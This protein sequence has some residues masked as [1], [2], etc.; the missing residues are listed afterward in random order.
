MN[1]T[2]YLLVGKVVVIKHP[3]LNTKQFNEFF[4]HYSFFSVKEASKTVWYSGIVVVGLG[5]TGFI[6]FTI[7]K[8]L[9]ST[10]S[11]QAIY[12]KSL[13]KCCEHP[14]VC[15]LL[16]EPITG[17][18]EESS[19]GRRKR[20]RNVFSL[21]DW[22]LYLCTANNLSNSFCRHS[23]YF[24][25]GIEHLQLKFYIKGIR[26]SAS[27]YVDMEKINGSFE[28]SYLIV[29]IDNYS[30]ERIF[31]IDNR[32][33]QFTESQSEICSQKIKKLVSLKMCI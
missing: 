22:Y 16:G 6:L 32:E 28:Y 4:L 26:N 3:D 5:A 2:N 23:F 20:L 31:I 24:K 33:A 21:F 1:L 12:S 30:R 25:D 15:D 7:F 11:P 19:R 29:E 18:G 27:V 10:Q 8:E 17:F 13:K 9:F 14:R